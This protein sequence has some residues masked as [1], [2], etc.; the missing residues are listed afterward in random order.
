MLFSTGADSI[1]ERSMEGDVGVDA[2]IE[3]YATER[4]V[5]E[6]L[7]NLQRLANTANTTMLTV[8]TAKRELLHHSLEMLVKQGQIS[9][10]GEI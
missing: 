3:S 5:G 9:Q 2:A 1:L 6:F 8:K 4:D 10:K 7:E